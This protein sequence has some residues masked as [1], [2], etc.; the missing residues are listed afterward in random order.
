MPLLGIGARKTRGSKRDVPLSEEAIK[1]LRRLGDK[2]F[3]F[4]FSQNVDAIWRQKIVGKTNIEDLHF[5]DSRHTAITRLA[6]K[7]EVLDLARMV[8]VTDLKTLMVYYNPSASD[9]AS[10]LNRAS[11]F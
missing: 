3:N 9:V 1:I 11:S 8:G 2:V 4:S 7:L 5:H 10:R 6:L